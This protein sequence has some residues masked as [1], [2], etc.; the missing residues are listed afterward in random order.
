MQRAGALDRALHEPSWTRR[1]VLG[2][3]AALGVAGCAR[4]DERSVRF[5]AMGREG[6]V[7]AE[8]LADFEHEHP[9]VR[10]RIEQLPW[11]AAHEKLLTAYA[12]DATPDI[13]QL[14]NTWLPEFVALD[15]LEPLDERV[16]ASPDVAAADYFPGIW[17]T[18]RIAGRLYGVPWY[19]DTRL[20]FYRRDLLGQAGFDAPPQTWAQWQQMMLAV[21]QR[22]GEKRYAILL[23][24]NEY[25]PLVALS[26]QQGEALLRDDGRWGNFRSEGFRRT[27]KFYL[28]MFEQRLAPAAS[29]N[30]IAN[31]WNEFARGFFSFYIS[32]PWQIGEFKRRL[33]AELQGAWATAPLPG[34]QGPGASIAGGSSLAVFRRSRRKDAAWQ[35]LQYLSRP[36]VQQRF[37]A[38]T[39]N[40]PP[41]RSAWEHAALAQD[42]PTLAF[43][44][45]LERVLPVPKVPEWER[46]ATELRVVT[47]ATVRGDIGAEAA[48]AELDLRADRILEKRR[49]MLARKAA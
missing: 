39:G 46:I 17:D 48:L 3:A 12:G 33:P 36:A 9:G 38:L 16:Q 15:A 14:G 23:P 22:V 28:S 37:Y 40:L 41:R 18:N 11:T 26:L 25:D 8:L 4:S 6:E 1:A 43:R 34:P 44:D 20:L 19:V 49:W 35:L 21:K 2:A 7:A 27:W 30:E 47:E 10:V 13:A 5:W 24:L 29:A 31:V 32:G 45:Q 42:A